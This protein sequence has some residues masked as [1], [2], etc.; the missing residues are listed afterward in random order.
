MDNQDREREKACRMRIHGRVQGVGFRYWAQRQAQRN[1]V[2]G[3][4]RN[5]PDGTVLVECEGGETQVNNFLAVLRQG[6]PG[7]A[8]QRVELQDLPLQSSRR[9]F[10]I[11]F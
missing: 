8:V 2:A 11:E 10:T 6:P 3:W 9:N 7:A 5:E 1:G 4:V